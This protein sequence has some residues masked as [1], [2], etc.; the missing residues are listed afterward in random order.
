MICTPL[1]PIRVLLTI[2]AINHDERTVDGLGRQTQSHQRELGNTT[3]DCSAYCRD[4][5]KL[6]PIEEDDTHEPLRT[7]KP[8]MM[9]VHA[10]YCQ[11]KGP[12]SHSRL[13]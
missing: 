10:S 6:I 8:S 1:D 11:Q 9:D 7:A 12:D 3:A 2:A 13:N 5:T 4:T